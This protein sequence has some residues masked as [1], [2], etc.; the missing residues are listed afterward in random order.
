LVFPQLKSDADVFFGHNVNVEGSFPGFAVE[1][2]IG[3]NINVQG[4]VTFPT[5]RTGFYGQVGEKPKSS[6]F[7]GRQET[8]VYG[9]RSSFR[10]GNRRKRWR[11]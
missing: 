4:A 9:D 3:L 1:G 6:G 2:E 11:R 5:L 10:Y 8:T 7:I